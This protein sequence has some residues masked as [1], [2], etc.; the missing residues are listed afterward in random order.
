MDEEAEIL[1]LVDDEDRVIGRIKRSDSRKLVSERLGY[2]RATDMFI[3]NSVGKLWLPMRTPHKTIAPNGLDYSCGG[4][5]S[6]GDD[7]DSTIEREI[8][9]EL[10]FTPNPQKLHFILKMP[11]LTTP[12]FR[13]IYIYESDDTPDYNL[14]DFV[15]G[16][17]MTPKELLDK[18]E[19]G[20]PAKSSIKETVLKLIELKKI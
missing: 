5:V 20:A 1:D 14:D 17:W 11:P 9:E 2:I 13:A 3:R 16:E 19:S 15:G 12:Y 4:H 18:L 8:E 7:Y 6:S 10:K